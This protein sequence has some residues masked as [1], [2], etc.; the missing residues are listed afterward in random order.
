[1]VLGSN[2]GLEDTC[3]MALCGL[4]GRFAYGNLCEEKL[5]VWMERVWSP[6]LGYVPEV[7]YLTKGWMGFL[8]N[9]PE[10]VVILLGM[11]WVNGA[12]N[13]MLKRWWIAFNPDT[14]YFS[15]RHIWVL[16]PGLPLYLWNEGALTAIGES[17]GKFI[18][19]DKVNLLATTIKV[20]RVLVEM[21]IH[22]GLSETIEIEW[23]GKRFLQRIDY[24]GI[25]FRCSYCRSNSHFS[26]IVKV[27]VM[28]IM[29]RKVLIF[30]TVHL[31]PQWKQVSMVLKLSNRTGTIPATWRALPQ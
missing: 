22:L 29:H 13:L 16:L 1:M 7:F 8:C 20:G 23:K 11:N 24:L 17:L 14:E 2:I 9:Y 27:L 5:I 19:I 26:M 25:S 18:M 31:I 15:L 6:V 21:D 28:A 30:S 3:R 12:S 10:D 4:V